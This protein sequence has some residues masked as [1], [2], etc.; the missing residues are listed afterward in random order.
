[1][2]DVLGTICTTAFLWYCGA[3]VGACICSIVTRLIRSNKGEDAR[4]EAVAL[5]AKKQ[6]VREGMLAQTPAIAQAKAEAAVAYQRAQA[7]ARA[8]IDAAFRRGV[9]TAQASVIEAYHNGLRAGRAS[10]AQPLGATLPAGLNVNDLIALCHPDRHPTER[11]A[12]A[13]KVTAELL[14]LRQKENPA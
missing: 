4:L 5:E 2:F 12:V 11:Q 10:S 7:E 1:M 13:N 9:A 3:F 6:G 14:K 8:S